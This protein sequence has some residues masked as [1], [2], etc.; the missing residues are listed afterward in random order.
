MIGLFD[1][2]SK[3]SAVK[4]YS[5]IIN[6]KPESVLEHMAAVC[7]FAEFIVN[8]LK[9][10]PYYADLN[11]TAEDELVLLKGA[12]FHD[13]D[14]ISIGDICKLN[15]YALMD[16]SE[17]LH[18]IER[19]STKNLFEKHGLPHEWFDYWN[20]AKAGKVGLILVVADIFSVAQRYHTE[21]MML[22]NK[23]F[24]EIPQEFKKELEALHSQM[25]HKSETFC[26]KFALDIAEPG[27]T[28]FLDTMSNHIQS[29]INFLDHDN[30][31]T[32]D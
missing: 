2:I 28:E 22:G 15:K 12:L 7:L 17:L 30:M 11:L 32:M 16:T 5:N 4:R 27:V 29:I 20:S 14:Q 21:Y 24:K 9:T 31:S 26:S 8:D 13:V 6:L 1:I 25:S 10:Q 19:E 23:Y 3:M 18:K